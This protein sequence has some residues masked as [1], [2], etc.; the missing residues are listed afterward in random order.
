[1]TNYLSRYLSHLKE[2]IYP[3]QNLLKK[4]VLW[5]WSDSQ[6]HAFRTVKR[7]IVNRPILAFYDPNKELTAVNDAS[8]YGLAAF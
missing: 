6:E 7:L 3:L 4:N 5:T 1:M 8:N 2:A